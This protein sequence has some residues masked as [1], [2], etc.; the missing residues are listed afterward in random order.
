MERLVS[1][2]AMT[3]AEE[4]LGEEIAVYYVKMRTL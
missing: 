3:C 1:G 4:Y 2:E